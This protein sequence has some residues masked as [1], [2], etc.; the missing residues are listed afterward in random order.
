[1][2]KYSFNLLLA[3]TACLLLLVVGLILLE[4]CTTNEQT[5]AY[6]TLYSTEQT[7]T[8]AYNGYL[9]AIMKGTVSTNS[10]PAISHDYNMF[11]ADMSVAVLLVQNT[12]NALAPANLVSEGSAIVTAISTAK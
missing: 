6:N 8:A 2:K 9:A 4:G 7:T 12:T 11:Q 3:F 5:T 10:L 1:M